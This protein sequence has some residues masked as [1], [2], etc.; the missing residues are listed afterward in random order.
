MDNQQSITDVRQLPS[1]ITINPYKSQRPGAGRLLD[2]LFRRAQLANT[3]TLQIGHRS[4]AE[5]IGMSPGS[6]PRLMN[7]LEAAG[8]IRRHAWKNSYL[9]EILAND[10]SLVDQSMIDQPV[11]ESACDIPTPQTDDTQNR[12]ETPCMERVMSHESESESCTP[13][14]PQNR[15]PAYDQQLYA[16]L[17]HESTEENGFLAMKIAQSGVGTLTEFQA[18]LAAARRN[19]RTRD[20][21]GL[22]LSYWNQGRRLPRQYV[23]RSDLHTQQQKEQRHVSQHQQPTPTRLVESSHPDAHGSTGSPFNLGSW[24]PARP[25]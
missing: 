19:P 1:H 21:F 2:E 8:M 18:D 6:I 22:V 20:A 3:T 4:L 25:W 12:V 24:K 13:A 15:L 17:T 9:V 23:S 14:A 5:A 10:Q 16:F 7:Q 11:I